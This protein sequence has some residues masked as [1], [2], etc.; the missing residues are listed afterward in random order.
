MNIQEFSN[1]DALADSLAARVSDALTQ[2]LHSGGAATMAVSGGSTPVKFFETLAK[3]PLDWKHVTITLVDDRWVPDSSRR[4]NA[5]LVRRHLLRHAAA[6]A[7]FLPL[8]T[9]HETPEAGR[10]TVEATIAALSLPLTV[11]ILGLGTDGH[12]ASLFP[13]GDRLAEALAPPAGR[14][15]ETMHSA[16]ADEPRITLTLPVLLQAENLFLHIEGETKRHVLETA[17]RPGP[18]EAM[19]IRAILA[20]DPPPAIFWCP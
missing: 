20:R 12:T 14:L 5:A 11:A 17:S 18:A 1:P 7:H 2:Q 16:A 9:Q 6:E 13:G 15:V 10:D 19:P 8:V 4:S 3:M